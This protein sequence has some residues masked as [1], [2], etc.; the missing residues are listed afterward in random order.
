MVADASS[1]LLLTIG[2]ALG[3]L[4]AVAAAI[5]KIGDVVTKRRGDKRQWERED[6]ESVIGEM[7]E[8]NARCWAEN[9]RQRATITEKDEEIERLEQRVQYRRDENHWLNNLLSAYVMLHGEIQMST[10]RPKPPAGEGP[11]EN[12]DP[13]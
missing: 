13:A 1:G 3:A 5:S 7:K 4:A 6:F 2:S 9:T 10:P 11:D 8:E 12:G